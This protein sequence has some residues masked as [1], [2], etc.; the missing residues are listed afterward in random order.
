MAALRAEVA[1]LQA[2]REDTPST[3]ETET[4]VELALSRKGHGQVSIKTKE[5]PDHAREELVAI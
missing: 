1:R 4:R 2:E 3:L 5:T